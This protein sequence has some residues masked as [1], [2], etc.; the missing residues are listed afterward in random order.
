MEWNYD[1]G[2]RELL[3]VIRALEEWWHYLLGLLHEVVL[4]SDHKNLGY[5][6]QPQKLNPQQ[7]RCNIMLSQYN[8]KSVH[9]PGTRMIQSDALS[10]WPD[11]CP[12][13]DNDNENVTLLPEQMFIRSIDTN[14]WDLIAQ[15]RNQ[16][17]VIVDALE[18]LK[19]HEALPMQS[20]LSDW[21]IEDDLVFY[22]NRCYVPNN[23]ELSR[24]VVAWYHNSL[25][26]G[27]PGHLQM[28]NLI[29][30]NYWWP[31][32]YTFIKNYTDGC[33]VCQ[34]SKI[35]QHLTSPPLMP[36]KES[37]TGRPF[38]QISVDFITNLPE[39]HRYDLIMIVVDHGL[40]KGVILCPCNK[41]IT[42]KGTAE[43]LLNNM[44]KCLG[45]PDKAISD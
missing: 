4:L 32:M 43:L 38:A 39:S 13:E 44:Y 33:A 19:T 2:N 10:Q 45:L 23:K 16:D 18:A 1:I 7:A 6:K 24:K 9:V 41:T 34:Q 8:L 3:A 37:L 21:K 12:K 27:H 11:L 20:S 30:N 25:P 42:A 17:Y 35:N 31:G 29:Q 5:F 14:L 28:M 15:T 22:K 36:V 40:T 26:V